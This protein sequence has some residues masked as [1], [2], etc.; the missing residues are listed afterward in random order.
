MGQAYIRRIASV[1]TIIMIVLLMSANSGRSDDSRQ[2]GQVMN[3]KKRVMLIGASVGQAWNL[4]G[5]PRRQRI[6][7][8]AFESIA[9]WQYDKTEAL[10]E[11]LM[12]PKRKFHL[13]RA[14]FSGFFQPAPQLPNIIIIKECAA[15]FPGDFK[16][17]KQSIQKWTKQIKDAHIQVIL[18]TVVPVTRERSQTR[19]GQ[20]ESILEF[21]DWIRE[22]AKNGNLVLIDLEA[23]LRESAAQ[24]FLKKELSTDGLHLNKQA[25]DLLDK[26]LLEA[27]RKLEHS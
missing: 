15:Y 4:L 12:R 27:L 19:P 17:Y 10:Q 1:I 18:A 6:N 16:E 23:Q 2:E 22:Y 8:Y 3:S 20:I 25:Y 11:V 21:N 7:E 5:L 9:A 26:E 24:R 13:T 14:Y